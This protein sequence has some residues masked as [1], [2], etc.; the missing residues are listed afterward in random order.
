ME[1][2]TN[3]KGK[4]NKFVETNINNII[5]NDLQ[6]APSIYQSN[7]FDFMLHGQGNAVVKAT[8]GSGKTSTIVNAIRLIPKKLRCLFIAF[9]KEIVKELERKL[10]GISNVEVKTVH[11]LGLLMIRRNFTEI[12]EIDQYK[13]KTFIKKNIGS[14]SDIET[15]GFNK[16][17]YEQY[18]D[19]IIELVD[20]GRLNLCQ[21]EKELLVVIERH[22]ISILD[23]ECDVVLK[24]LKWGSENIITIDFTDMVWLPYELS[25]KPVGL[26]YD[27]ILADEIQDFS[28]SHRELF[29]RCFKRGTRFIGVGDENQCQPSGTKI[30]MGNDTLKNIEDV[31]IGDKVIS[32]F[33]KTKCHYKGYNNSKYADKVVAIN[34]RIVNNTIKITTENGLTSEYTYEHLTYA[35]FNRIKTKGAYALYLMCNENGMYRIGKTQLFNDH[36]NYGFG[37]KCRMR[38]EACYKAWI[39][40]IF[41]SEKEARMNEIYYSTLFSIPQ[42]VFKQERC[43][44]T[45]FN[46]VDI[47]S[48]YNRIGDLT[49][50]VSKCLKHFNKLY[51]HPFCINDNSDK[52]S[53]EYMSSYAACNLFSDYMDVNIYDINNVHLR[54]HGSKYKS[55]NIVKGRYVNISKL[56]ILSDEKTVYSLEIENNHNYVADGI[57]T[58]N[59][60]YSFAG[61]SPESFKKLQELPNT[62]TFPLSISYRCAKNIVKYANSIVPSMEHKAEAED[63]VVIHNAHI[64]DIQNGD[65]VLCRNKMPL[66]KLYMR[67]LRMGIKSFVRGQDIGVN[68]LKMVSNTDKQELNTSLTNDG[69]FVR[70]YEKLFD[71]RN[72]LMIKRGL[73]IDDATFSDLVMNVYDSIKALETLSEGITTAAELS[74][75]INNVFTSDGEGICLSTIHKAKGLEADN[76]YILCRTLMPSKMAKKDWEIEQEQNITYVA[77]TRAKKKLAFVSEKEVSP[78]AA[79]IDTN[80]ARTELAYIEKTISKFTGKIPITEMTDVEASE[81]AIKN[82]TELKPIQETNSVKLN[83][84]AND[85]IEEVS[86]ADLLKELLGVVK[87]KGGM[88]KLKEF[89]NN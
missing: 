64:S 81:Y 69:V 80:V 87:K 79:M 53:R 33:D 28:P 25:L 54:T 60:L 82:I 14:L 1:K 57:L 47:V 61:S 49:E 84:K 88:K 56:E 10:N 38:N 5:Y 8:A 68:L 45:Y 2:E 78:S 86:D 17:E 62:T 22:D 85:T 3:K 30:S 21:C 59:C 31:E 11:S 77:Y 52:H 26:Q 7:I 36:S 9:N 43:G 15:K 75:R 44:S 66:I 32:Y 12:I 35:K 46:D 73:D 29:L 58:H 72:K 70:L 19:N 83:D 48:L 34:K 71:I 50:N 6:F 65:M 51:N 4:Q 40:Q 20:L 63:G 55:Y 27:W 18:I 74:L 41:P 23:D 37:L 24:V 76:V 89:L 67:F 42:I 13:Y 39:L 16:R